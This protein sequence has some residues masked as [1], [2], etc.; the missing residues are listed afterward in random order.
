MSIREW[1]LQF[2]YLMGILYSFLQLVILPGT[3]IKIIDVAIWCVAVFIVVKI[4]VSVGK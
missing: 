2:K 1:A 4:L 3:N